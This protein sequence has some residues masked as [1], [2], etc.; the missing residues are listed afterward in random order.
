[1]GEAMKD[2]KVDLFQESQPIIAQASD[3][4]GL[5]LHVRVPGSPG[6]K[7]SGWRGGE[8]SSQAAELFLRQRGAG[9]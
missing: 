3:V 9:Q 2:I 6:Q 1:M 5:W 8:L 4:S 7:V